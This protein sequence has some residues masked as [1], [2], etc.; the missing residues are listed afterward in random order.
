MTKEQIEKAAKEYFGLTDNSKEPDSR[1]KGALCIAFADGAEWR[2]N[3]VWHRAFDF[4]VK[5]KLCLVEYIDP[6]GEVRI[7]VDWHSEYEWAEMCHYDE[8][9]RWAYIDDLLPTAQK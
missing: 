9:L 6:K 7:R 5:E 1:M 4:P 2:I 3:A 8:V